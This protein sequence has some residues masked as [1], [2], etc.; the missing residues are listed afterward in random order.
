M[1]AWLIVIL[2]ALAAPLA[3]WFAVVARRRPRNDRD[4]NPEVERVASGE[5]D[6]DILTIRNLR[7]SVYGE[8]G[9]PFEVVWTER[10]FDLATLQRVWLAV[11][12][13]SSIRGIAHTFLSFE[14][15]EG[16]A[17]AV[18]VEARLKRGERYS[19]WRGL[20]RTFE[21]A[22]TV[23]TER[24]FVLKRA[25][26]KQRD[27][28]LLPLVT[29]P[30]EARR[31][32]VDMIDTA[33]ELVGEPRFYHSVT[34]N[35]TTAL[36]DHANAVRPGSL[37]LM[38]PAKVLPGLSPDALQ[39]KGWIAS[40]LSAAEQRERFEVGGRARGIGAVPDFSQRLREGL[41]P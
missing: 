1:P 34:D 24:D 23:G 7:D 41:V 11:E 13:F 17:L 18:S 33:N 12:S 6:G 35:C 10:A 32:L 27:V 29:P 21:L 30:D 22:Y 15:T 37:P 38:L 39:R 31:L 16:D 28:L 36:A 26:Y 20:F 5:L 4:W 2:L 3:W 40:G 8:P 9:T 14:F 25:A 19:I